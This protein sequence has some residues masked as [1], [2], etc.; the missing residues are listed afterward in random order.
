MR[1]G[2]AGALI[3]RSSIV[4]RSGVRISWPLGQRATASVRFVQRESTASTAYQPALD[5]FIQIREGSSILFLGR[6]VEIQDRPLQAP[7]TGTE[8]TIQAVDHTEFL[9]QIRI[10]R[11]YSETSLTLKQ[12][13]IDLVTSFLIPYGISYDMTP[14]G[15]TLTPPPVFNDVTAREVFNDLAAATG[16]LWRMHTINETTAEVVVFAPGDKTADFAELRASLGDGQGG[17]SWTLSRG[18]YANRIRLSY[19]SLTRK[20]IVQSWTGNG[21][22][23]TFDLDYPLA[24]TFGYVYYPGS[25]TYESIGAV[26]AGGVWETNYIDVGTGSAPGATAGTIHRTSGAVANGTV[27]QLTYA[28]QFPAVIIAEDSGEI[29]THGVWEELFEYPEIYDRDTADAI[30]S[31][32]LTQFATT[33]RIVTVTT[34]QSLALVGDAVTLE[35]PTRDI[36]AADYLISNIEATL[37]IDGVLEY[38]LTCAESV[39]SGQGWLNYFGSGAGRGSSTTTVSGITT[40]QTSGFFEAGISAPAGVYERSRSGSHGRVG[41]VHA[42]RRCEQRH[43]DHLRDYGGC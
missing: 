13:V 10:T 4:A 27:F 15:P 37:A 34:R 30:A 41:R 8:T 1:H 14:S 31:N 3:D 33:P 38:Q 40:P 6:V 21:V 43:R 28:A 29:F 39:I 9:D 19:G 42:I 22:L 25:N 12:I 17:V 23:T 36:S 7:D 11:E 18:K 26:G 24:Q 5:D 32:L 35:F 16:Y 20:E 2:T